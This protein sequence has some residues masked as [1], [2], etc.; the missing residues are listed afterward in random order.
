MNILTALKNPN[1]NKKL[2]IETDFNIV[3]NDI[4]YQEGILEM[5]QQ[6][7]KIDLIILS[8]LLPGEIEFKELINKIKNINKKI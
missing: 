1:I 5:L 4:Q 2:K 6:N 7:N 3:G 8:E